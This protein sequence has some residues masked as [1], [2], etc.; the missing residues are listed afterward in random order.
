MPRRDEMQFGNDTY[1]NRTYGARQT[2]GGRSR[3]GA[4][5]GGFSGRTS[6]GFGS[7]IQVAGG[8]SRDVN[9]QDAGTGAGGGTGESPYVAPQDITNALGG[10]PPAT[11]TPRFAPTGAMTAENPGQY[12]GTSFDPQRDIR[13]MNEVSWTKFPTGGAN[14]L[15][16]G[17]QN[18]DGVGMYTGANAQ[19][20]TS[21]FTPAPAPQQDPLT[22]QQQAEQE[23]QSLSSQLFQ[24]YPELKFSQY[25]SGNPNR[26]GFSITDP[27]VQQ[28][29]STAWGRPLN[30]ALLGEASLQNAAGTAAY[31]PAA[32]AATLR[33]Y[34]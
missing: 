8:R 28:H 11:P 4:P 30:S 10:N 6:G 26:G 27:S 20:D 7:P 3:G 18:V 22:A 17:S 5:D 9:Q 21:K 29:Y 31:D 12:A 13:N 19:L 2:T 25:L 15:P 23:V 16:E 14:S 32:I 34:V 33:R 24:R 1:G